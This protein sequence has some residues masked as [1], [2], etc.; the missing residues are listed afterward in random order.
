MRQPRPNNELW[1]VEWQRSGDTSVRDRII[2]ANIGLVYSA[3][4]RF[5]RDERIDTDEMWQHGL[6]ALNDA[7]NRFDASRGWQFTTY[8]CT[9]INRRI[10]RYLNEFKRVI[11]VA[12]YDDR[13]KDAHERACNP[14]EV[15]EDE[16][17]TE[18]LKA[19]MNVALKRLEPRDAMILMQRFGIVCEDNPDGREYS[20]DQIAETGGLS[21]ERVRQLENRGLKMLQHYMGVRGIE[22]LSATKRKSSKEWVKTKR[23]RRVA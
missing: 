11:S 12:Q 23:K 4:K 17:V 5:C 10:F 19:K 13:R 3:V 15:F 8:A 14:L 9:A 21:R 16:E 22:P 6:I 7:I 2:R 20:L 18:N 1:V